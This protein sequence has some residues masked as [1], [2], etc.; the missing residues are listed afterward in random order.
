MLKKTLRKKI[1]KNPSFYIAKQ[2]RKML[3]L[4]RYILRGICRPGGAVQ[5]K[6]RG[7]LLPTYSYT[8]INVLPGLLGRCP[9]RA[10]V[11]KYVHTLWIIDAV[12]AMVPKGS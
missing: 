4:T 2:Y 8:L 7:A 9:Q 1:D 5:A 12:A 10:S 6:L 3:Y 11:F